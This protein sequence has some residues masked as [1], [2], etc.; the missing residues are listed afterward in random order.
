MIVAARRSVDGVGC[1]PRGRPAG[2]TL[3]FEG[4]TPSIALHVPLV[5]RRVMHE[6]I[7]RGQRHGRIGKD[8]SPFAGGLVCGEEDRAVFVARADKLEQHAGFRLVLAD[9]GEVVERTG[10][11]THRA[12]CDLGGLPPVSRDLPFGRQWR[13]VAPKRM[14]APLD[15]PATNLN[16]NP[17][18]D[19]SARAA[20]HL[21]K[22]IEMSGVTLR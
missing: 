11:G 19:S 16:E 9:V 13:S 3:S 1:C 10:P 8:L 2:A 20:C 14:P 7:D 6:T 22:G 15:E 18:S 21:P 4:R 5:D 17:F 12:G